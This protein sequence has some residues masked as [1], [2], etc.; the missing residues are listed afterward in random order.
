MAF[1]ASNVTSN[2]QRFAFDPIAGVPKGSGTWV[3]SGSTI[4]LDVDVSPDGQRIAYRAGFGQEDIVV[5]AADGS[6]ALQLTNDAAR[7]RR[8]RWSP[9]GRT[10]AFYSDRSGRYEIWTIGADGAGLRQ[11]TDDPQVLY[12]VWSPDGTRIAGANAQNPLASLFDPRTGASGQKPERLPAFADEPFS[13]SAWSSDGRKIAGFGGTGL[14]VYDVES[15][16]YEQ[17]A[18]TRG[19]SYPYW[20]GLNRLV[21][22]SNGRL[23]LV[24]LKTRASR[25][26]L[27]VAPEVIRNFSLSADGTHLVISRGVTESD[28]WMA[29]LK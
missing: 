14:A 29:T 23:M 1:T 5:S 20:L 10:L 7:D 16:T 3:T 6:A 17:I 18:Q 12:S 9:D 25:D 19:G 27:P 28:V 2:I 4:R 21:Y 24:D 26:V 13:P 8:P 15:R 22:S 11:V